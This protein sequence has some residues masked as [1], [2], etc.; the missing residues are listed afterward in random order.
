ML[1]INSLLILTS[2]LIGHSALLIAQFGNPKLHKNKN[3]ALKV[4]ATGMPPK[5][6]RTI[7]RLIFLSC[8]EES[9]TE[10]HCAVTG[11][12]F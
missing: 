5:C 10:A 9:F 11:S 7:S 1:N 3:K 12:V 6:K 2:S 4:S 8:P